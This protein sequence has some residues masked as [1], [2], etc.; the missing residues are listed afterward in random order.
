MPHYNEILLSLKTTHY[1]YQDKKKLLFGRLL[2][3]SSTTWLVTIK[4]LS[5][6][7]KLLLPSI[8]L[9]LSVLFLTWFYYYTNILLCCIRTQELPRVQESVL[10]KR[11]R[12]LEAKALANKETARRLKVCWLSRKLKF[13]GFLHWWLHFCGKSFILVKAITK[14]KKDVAMFFVLSCTDFFMNLW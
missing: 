6:R 7:N 13:F 1:Y 3:D 10:K 4:K 8:I 12:N 5:S 14:R 11:R 2:Y 9:L